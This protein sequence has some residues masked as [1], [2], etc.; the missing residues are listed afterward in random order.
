MSRFIAA[1]TA[2]LLCSLPALALADSFQVGN[3]TNRSLH[4]S[5]RCNDGS[6]GWH[7]FTLGS[8][9]HRNYASGRW[10][11]NCGAERYQLRIETTAD[12]GSHQYT[13]IPVAPG[14]AYALVYSPAHS[15]FVAYDTRWMVAMRNDARN[16]VHVTYRCVD[17]G[18]AHGIAGV[19]VGKIGWFYSEGCS[20]YHVLTKAKNNDGTV[21]SWSRDIDANDVYR[22]RWNS[23]RQAYVLEKI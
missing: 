19:A 20:R 23:D 13:T 22:I 5:L 11:Y 6:D 21:T 18:D 2:V 9:A 7:S 12:D 16:T 1:I 4:F 14:H 3:I 17:G 10:G 15:G 8:L